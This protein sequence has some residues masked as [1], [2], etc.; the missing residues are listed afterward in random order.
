ML[1]VLVVLQIPRLPPTGSVTGAASY[2]LDV[3]STSNFSSILS[4]YNNLTVSGT[5]QSVTGLTSGTTYYYRVRAI[6]SAGSSSV[7]SNV[8]TVLPLPAAT[9]T[10]PPSSITTTSFVANWNAGTNASGYQLDV[11]ADGFA[12]MISGYNGVI[13]GGT[14][15]TVTGLTANTTY[16]YRVRST[17]SSGSSG[18]SNSQGLITLPA[19]PATNS[20]SNLTSSSFQANWSG[21]TT[22]YQLDVSTASNFT[23]F[24]AGYNNLLLTSTNAIII[25]SPAC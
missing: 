12:T 21:S 7:S 15:Q 18:N 19:A 17:N 25:C 8:V 24:L 23:T 4:G 16:Y 11:S 1:V 3:A 9:T 14:S 6:N 5:S 10:L 22:Q 20:A 13:V 2:R